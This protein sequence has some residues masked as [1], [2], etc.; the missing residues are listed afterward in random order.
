ML[1][2]DGRGSEKANPS[3][4]PKAQAVGALKGVHENAMISV[5]LPI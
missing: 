2:P 5:Y 1:L 3:I 4:T